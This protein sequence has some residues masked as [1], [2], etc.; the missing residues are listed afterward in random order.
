MKKKVHYFFA[1]D[2]T[3]LANAIK[4]IFFKHWHLLQ[5]ILGCNVNPYMGFRRTKS[6]QN[7]LVRS[8][9]TVKKQSNI[10]IKGHFK[11][12]NCTICLITVNLL[13]RI[14]WRNCFRERTLG[15]LIWI[16]SQGVEHLHWFL[17][18][19]VNIHYSHFWHFQWYYL[20]GS[21]RIVY[22]SH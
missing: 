4:I 19:F 15:S 21:L 16:N 17:L 22:E 2:Y 9:T 13:I 20:E 7:V 12:G 6:L 3:P 11:G 18:L 5:E 10:S 1:L 8:D 14:Y